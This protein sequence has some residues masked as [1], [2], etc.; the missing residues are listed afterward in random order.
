MVGFDSD[1]FLDVAR[2][3]CGDELGELFERIIRDHREG[4]RIKRRY[5]HVFRNLRVIPA[6]D[7]ILSLARETGDADERK[8]YIAGQFG[9]LPGNYVPDVLKELAGRDLT[10][11]QERVI[12]GGFVQYLESRRLDF[13][14]ANIGV[15]GWGPEVRR[16]G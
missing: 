5:G 1:V 7:F 9:E 11:D 8:R 4:Q 15:E 16:T 2:E 10:D 12:Y 13:V 3:E 14:R 6:V